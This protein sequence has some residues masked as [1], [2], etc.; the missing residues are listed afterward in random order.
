[1]HHANVKK[2]MRQNRSVPSAIP[3][4]GSNLRNQKC[5]M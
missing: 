5:I 2:K 3:K 4:C 1:M